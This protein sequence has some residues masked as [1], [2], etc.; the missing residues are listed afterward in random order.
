MINDPYKVLGVSRDASADEIKSAYRNL[1]K[2]YHPD[3][4]PDDPKAAERM[5]DINVAYDMLTHQKES[6][7]N[8]KGS[9]YNAGGYGNSGYSGYSTNG[10]AYSKYDQ[11][12]SEY[13]SNINIDDLFKFFGSAKNVNYDFS[14]IFG[15]PGG[16]TFSRGFNSRRTSDNTNINPDYESGDS[17][18]I[19]AIISS[20][21]TGRY[22][23]AEYRLMQI[24]YDDRDAR[25]HY[26]YSLALYGDKDY[27]Q[28][29]QYIRQAINLEPHNDK[30]Q[31]L[32][33]KYSVAEENAYGSGS[34]NSVFG[35]S[36]FGSTRFGNPVFRSSKYGFGNYR[37]GGLYN[38][39]TG[40][41]RL[42][43]I[44]LLFIIFRMILG[45]LG[46]FLF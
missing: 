23:D 33:I 37:G 32:L 2:K 7:T 19:I 46:F 26:L 38:L 41:R 35:N 30:Y 5:N 24:P 31:F 34:S 16:R 8:N 20:I 4:H 3:L 45:I 13:G 43:T 42:G 1:A 18:S 22:S 36:I 40:V 6:S 25:W 44:I 27:T 11:T 28:A 15:W 14:E 21:N 9:N 39:V 29:I 17:E 10:D 12:Y